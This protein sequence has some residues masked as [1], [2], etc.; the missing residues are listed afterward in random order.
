MSETLAGRTRYQGL[1]T[2][3]NW[4]KWKFFQIKHYSGSNEVRQQ[5]S[6]FLLR[7]ASKTNPSPLGQL[8]LCCAL[9]RGT[10][11]LAISSQVTPAVRQGWNVVPS[12]VNPFTGSNGSLGG[13]CVEIPVFAGVKG[14]AAA[15]FMPVWFT[16]TA[17]GAGTAAPSC[18]QGFSVT[19]VVAATLCRSLAWPFLQLPLCSF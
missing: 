9:L 4:L 11:S 12:Q 2:R 17:A 14:W 8:S 6:S 1:K 18:V 3:T 10:W 15:S 19:L 7:K 5:P 13:C 16:L